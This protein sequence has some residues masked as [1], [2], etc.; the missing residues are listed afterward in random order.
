MD[1]LMKRYIIW[2]RKESAHLLSH[3]VDDFYFG[4]QETA[5][6]GSEVPIL[7]F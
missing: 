6:N 5:L 2:G 3:F 1:E 4:T 7:L